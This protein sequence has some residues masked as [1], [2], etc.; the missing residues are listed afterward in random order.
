MVV[1]GDEDK[2]IPFE[3]GERLGEAIPGAKFV[4]LAGVGHMPMFEATNELA[5]VVFDFL[6]KAE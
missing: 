6:G 4:R 5:R 2:L 1:H 3:N